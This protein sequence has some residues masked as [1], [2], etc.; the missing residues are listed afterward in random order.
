M[1]QSQVSESSKI[2]VIS[3]RRFHFLLALVGWCFLLWV[4]QFVT[5]TKFSQVLA[6]NTVFGSFT[7]FTT[8]LSNPNSPIRFDSLDELLA[9]LLIGIPIYM[10]Y[11]Q[12]R[13]RVLEGTW[14]IIGNS[15]WK[16]AL[17][18]S[19]LFAS[20]CR[21]SL[22]P[23][24]FPFFVDH[25]F[26][27]AGIDEFTRSLKMGAFANYSTL[28]YSG[29][30]CR[31]YIGNL[32][33][34]LAGVLA[35]LTNSHFGVK[36][37]LWV[38]FTAS[39]IGMF[40][41][42]EKLT[43]SR[44]AAIFSSCAFCL[45]YWHFYH[46]FGIGQLPLSIVYA[47]LPWPFYFFE[48]GLAESRFRLRYF[49]L[50][51]IPLAGIVYT[52]FVWGAMVWGLVTLYCLFRLAT[53][54]LRIQK[55]RS[56]ILFAI[57]FGLEIFI[58]AGMVTAPIV[59]KNES[60]AHHT[61]RNFE[62]IQANPEMRIR[63][64]VLYQ[65]YNGHWFI[66]EG[67]KAEKIAKASF[68]NRYL[69][70]VPLLFALLG[71]FGLSR[72]FD[73][74]SNALKFISVFLIG[75]IVVVF[76]YFELVRVPGLT[77]LR[78]FPDHRYQAFLVFFMS[79]GSGFGILIW[80]RW[81]SEKFPR[82][83]NLWGIIPLVFLALDV[84]ATT[85]QFPFKAATQDKWNFMERYKAESKR[86][87]DKGENV[88]Y[89]F[90]IEEEKAGD[91]SG[92]IPGSMVRRIGMPSELGIQPETGPRRSIFGQ[93]FYGWL[94]T[95]FK[96]PHVFPDSFSLNYF[97]LN[98]FRDVVLHGD[99]IHT[100]DTTKLE[101]LETDDVYIDGRFRYHTPVIASSGI[102]SHA[103]K[104]EEDP[105]ELKQLFSDMNLDYEHSTAKRIFVQAGTSFES[106]PASGSPVLNL[107][108]YKVYPK[109][110]HY[111]I[112]LNQPAYVRLAASY[113]SYLQTSIDGQKTPF[114]PG[115]TYEIVLKVPAGEHTI[116]VEGVWDPYRKVWL[117]I[118][119]IAFGVLGF[120]AI[121]FPSGFGR[122]SDD[123]LD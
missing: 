52:H 49:L 44:Y 30:N 14:E 123:T 46:V 39:G 12:A 78:I 41:W 119:W 25:I 28:F 65:W 37:I 88:P 67:S 29:W 115:A 106:L 95:H 120:L 107:L 69:G 19:F 9:V 20:F 61:A 13:F 109:K 59:Q 96:E 86:Y 21:F 79:A 89:Y 24:E 48:L 3:D 36:L 33:S 70:L 87:L 90:F 117:Y 80:R 40:L 53:R 97:Y 16:K 83:Q 62:A 31:Q 103:W 122:V 18:L 50:C 74:D 58:L 66:G 101:D 91:Y 22:H 112:R 118:T 47:C 76:F 60:A 105:S 57:S 93:T 108:D 7:D 68:F 43:R 2:L 1:S 11:L 23:G 55:K 72:R 42:I 104:N 38:A 121:K 64:E 114:Y 5:L 81:A 71:L 45:N 94:M 82:F 98:N 35:F 6:V 10:V 26:F 54:S 99:P 102:E 110:Y 100:F 34:V 51:A 84:G 56:F 8:Y 17:C 32:F 4:F 92:Q 63:P 27:V 15:T 77:F 85:F 113:Y 75:S 73:L 116:E 111:R